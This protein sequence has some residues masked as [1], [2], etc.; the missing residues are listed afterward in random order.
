M[1]PTCNEGVCR[2]DLN[3]NCALVFPLRWRQQD[4]AH[5]GFRKREREERQK[6]DAA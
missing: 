5:R 2:S 1:H 3:P 6:T 4:V